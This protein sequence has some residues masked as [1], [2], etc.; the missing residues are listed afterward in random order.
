MSGGEKVIT[1][2]SFIF[3]IQEYDPAP[4]YILDEVDAALDKDNSL[5]LAKLI[6]SSSRKAQFIMISHND[7]VYSNSDNLYGVSINPNGIS[8]VVGIKLP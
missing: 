5:T 6:K 2:L 3:A 7:D 4:F 1:A 8:Q